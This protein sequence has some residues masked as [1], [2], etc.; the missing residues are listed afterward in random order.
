MASVFFHSVFFHL[1]FSGN[2][3]CVLMDDSPCSL[4]QL[5]LKTVAPLFALHL[6]KLQIQTRIEEFLL[7]T[8]LYQLFN[9]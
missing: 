5:G 2:Q 3:Q 9:Q 1:T 4:G 8:V 6:T 7:G